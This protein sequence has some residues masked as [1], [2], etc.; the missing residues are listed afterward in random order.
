VATITIAFQVTDETTD[1]INERRDRENILVRQW[2]N[3]DPDRLK[4]PHGQGAHRHQGS[5]HRDIC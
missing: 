5:E 2:N 4:R 3:D 1:E